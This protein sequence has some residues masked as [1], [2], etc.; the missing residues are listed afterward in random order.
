V[1]VHGREVCPC[2][3][4][5]HRKTLHIQLAADL[6]GAEVQ[7]G[8]EDV[9]FDSRRLILCEMFES[10]QFLISIYICKTRYY[11]KPCNN[12]HRST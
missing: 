6:V 5:G 10:I 8:K 11:N 1:G 12:P 7:R 9:S 3:C 2:L 4:L